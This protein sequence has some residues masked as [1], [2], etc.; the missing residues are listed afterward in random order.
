MRIGIGTRWFINI[1][2]LLTNDF[3]FIFY[4]GIAIELPIELP[5]IVVGQHHCGGESRR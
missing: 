4:D 3:P 5:I 2:I 1:T